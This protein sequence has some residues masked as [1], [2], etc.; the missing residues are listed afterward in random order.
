M[1]MWNVILS[2]R[3]VDDGETILL[4]HL[5]RFVHSPQLGRFRFD[6]AERRR[7]NKVAGA[8]RAGQHDIHGPR[9]RQHARTMHLADGRGVEVSFHDERRAFFLCGERFDKPL[10]LPEPAAL[11]SRLRLAEHESPVA[12]SSKSGYQSPSLPEEYANGSDG[13]WKKCIVSSARIRAITQSSV[14]CGNILA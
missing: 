13:A 9:Q 5:E 3:H 8:Q 2:G 4:R 1:K 7:K 12:A 6:A 10:A 11:P 14:H